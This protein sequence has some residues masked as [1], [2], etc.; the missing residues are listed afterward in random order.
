MH[1]IIEVFIVGNIK[2]CLKKFEGVTPT[3]INYQLKHFLEF[4]Y[5]VQGIQQVTVLRLYIH[6]QR[7]LSYHNP[8]WILRR[9]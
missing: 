7:S 6:I 2:S 3:K 5:S 4:Q 9:G 1:G 8:G